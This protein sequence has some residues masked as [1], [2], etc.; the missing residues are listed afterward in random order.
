MTTAPSPSRPSFRACRG[1][2]GTPRHEHDGATRTSSEQSAAARHTIKRRRASSRKV[3]STAGLL[4]AVTVYAPPWRPVRSRLRISLRPHRRFQ[5]ARA[6]A[7]ARLGGVHSRLFWTSPSLNTRPS[8][9]RWASPSPLPD[10]RVSAPHDA[11]SLGAMVFAVAPGRRLDQGYGTLNATL[12]GAGLFIGIIV[13]AQIVLPDINEVPADFPASIS[14]NSAWPHS[15]CNGHLGARDLVRRLAERL[16]S[17]GC[18][19]APRTAIV[20]PQAD[21]SGTRA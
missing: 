1:G 16:L 3:Q 9:G 5:S 10:R 7:V 6:R 8:A 18:G 2:R 19:V 15:P 21:T 17:R 12:I 4:T 14:G 20:S 13:V 11:I